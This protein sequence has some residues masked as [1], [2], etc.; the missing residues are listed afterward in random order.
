MRQ[1]KDF[2]AMISEKTVPKSIRILKR[3]FFGL[4]AGLIAIASKLV[5]TSLL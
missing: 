2:K 5:F 4:F 3:T 1:L